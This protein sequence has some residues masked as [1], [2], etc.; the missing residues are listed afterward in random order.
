[1][2]VTDAE[3]VDPCQLKLNDFGLTVGDL[4]VLNSSTM[5]SGG[6]VFRIVKDCPP[7]ADA[8]WGEFMEA[9][10]WY[11]RKRV[12]S[13]CKRA[14]GW[15]WTNKNGKPS[16]RRIP[17]IR[18]K[19][20]IELVP[21]WSFFPQQAK[22]HAVSYAMLERTVKR[23]GL[24]DLGTAFATFHLFIQNETRRMSAPTLAQVPP[25]PGPMAPTPLASSA[26]E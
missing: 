22:K 1:M 19:G 2:H 9:V 11:D 16:R 10:P 7:V 4:V 14:L 5:N 12:G 15:V 3:R 20:C 8:R 18:L 13:S 17:H 26:Q 6:I 25:S 24:V 21:V 23:V